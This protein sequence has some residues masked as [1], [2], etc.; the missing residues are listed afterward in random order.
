[1]YV[2]WCLCVCACNK[3]FCMSRVFSQV[4]L[5]LFACCRAQIIFI[6]ETLHHEVE[7]WLSVF[8]LGRTLL[9]ARIKVLPRFHSTKRV[10][11]TLLCHHFYNFFFS[12]CTNIA[13]CMCTVLIVGAFATFLP[14]PNAP[15]FEC[16]EQGSLLCVKCHVREFACY[17]NDEWARGRSITCGLRCDCGDLELQAGPTDCTCRKVSS[18]NH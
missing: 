9:Q 10:C 17:W 14:C 12:R 16:S 5:P 6:C 1:M 8:H 18:P 2:S 4:S 11:C 13:A 3:C 7:V 15:V